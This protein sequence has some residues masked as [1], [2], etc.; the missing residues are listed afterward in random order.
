MKPSLRQ[1]VFPLGP[2]CLVF[3]HMKAL[4]FGY[5][6]LDCFTHLCRS[7][8]GAS[9]PTSSK[10]SLCSPKPNH[11]PATP[12]IHEIVIDDHGDVCIIA[13]TGAGEEVG[14]MV[15]SSVLRLQSP[16]LATLF[17]SN[18]AEGNALSERAQG[19]PP[20]N[21]SLLEDGASALHLLLRILHL[22]PIA[23]EVTLNML[24]DLA[25]LVDKYQCQSACRQQTTYCMKKQLRSNGFSKDLPEYLGLA[26]VFRNDEVFETVNLLM[27]ESLL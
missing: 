8:P 2:V 3:L 26:I 13:T 19:C 22:K 27:G 6:L 20:I 16:V 7:K 9:F 14:Y 18:F 17:G 15:S 24:L 23:E 25:V 4:L 10:P 5:F 11:T 12:A 1:C 21:V